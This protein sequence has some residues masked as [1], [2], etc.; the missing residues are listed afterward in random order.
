MINI[1]THAESANKMKRLGALTVKR[2]TYEEV[3]REKEFGLTQPK[4]QSYNTA[5]SRE[6]RRIEDAYRRDSPNPSI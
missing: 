4:E 1:E 3:S 2:L 5:T 6:T